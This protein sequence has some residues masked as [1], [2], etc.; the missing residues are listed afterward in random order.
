MGRGDGERTKRRIIESAYALFYKQG[1]SRSS[2]DDIAC[3]AGVTKR[4]LYAHFRSKDELLTAALDLHDELAMARIRIWSDRLTGGV[5]SVI[6]KVFSEFGAWASKPRWAGSGMTRL[7]MEL[8]DRP[9]HPGHVVARRHK[10]AVESWFAGEFARRHVKRPRERARELVL[11]LEGV[12]ALMLVHRDP[13]Y[14]KAAAKAVK[15][16]IR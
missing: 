9:G 12:N 1:F 7:A 3:R 4:T 13:D 6:D 8:A 5:D 14:A 11:M 16:L 15:R 10:S 2:V